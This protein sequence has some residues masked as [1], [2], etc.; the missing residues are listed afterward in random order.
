MDILKSN[1]K[2]AIIR[3]SFINT[4]ANKTTGTYANSTSMLI[5]S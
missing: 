2:Q 5:L 1:N 4:N 3:K